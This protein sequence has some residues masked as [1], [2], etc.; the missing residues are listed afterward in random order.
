MSF[1]KLFGGMN[2]FVRG[3]AE[4]KCGPIFHTVSLC[5]T[6]SFSFVRSAHCASAETRCAAGCAAG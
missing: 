3:A 2:M 5:R 4:S 1:P 6:Q